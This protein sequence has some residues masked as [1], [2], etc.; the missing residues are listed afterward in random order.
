MQKLLR[1]QVESLEQILEQCE[2]ENEQLQEERD[3]E[4]AQVSTLLCSFLFKLIS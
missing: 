4:K 2:K 1:T 3:K